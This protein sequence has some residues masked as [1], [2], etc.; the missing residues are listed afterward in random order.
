M[1]RFNSLLASV[2]I[3]YVLINKPSDSWQTVA[4]S[5]AVV[6]GLRNPPELSEVGAG[7]VATLPGWLPPGRAN[8]LNV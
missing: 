2:P 7:V 6:P 8:G 1:T 4:C 5:R 3:Q